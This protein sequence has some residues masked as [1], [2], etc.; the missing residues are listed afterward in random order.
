MAKTRHSYRPACWA[1][2]GIRAVLR[3]VEYL[4]LRVANTRRNG[5]R[6]SAGVDNLLKA[7]VLASACDDSTSVLD[8]GCGNGTRLEE[9]SLF[10]DEVV[11]LVG[12]DVAKREPPGLPGS[13]PPE[14]EAFDGQSLP[15]DN[16][17]F[18]TTCVCYVLHHLA[19]EHAER[20][21]AECLRVTRKRILI[22]ED[23]MPEWSTSYRLRNWA[24]L[25][26]ANMLY[27]EESDDFSTFYGTQGFL[28]QTEWQTQLGSM[29]SVDHVNIH[30]LKGIKRYEHHTMFEVVLS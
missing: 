29:L 13:R 22:L 15:F 7:R 21:L 30:Q 1:R 26:E 12:V 5:K 24:H 27:G 17:S 18:D 4:A 20:L 11:R 23:S 16:G 14:L 25:R 8:V 9:M 6:L 3:A 19:P 28:T 10:L 2:T